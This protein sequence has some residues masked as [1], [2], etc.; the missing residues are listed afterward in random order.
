[1]SPPLYAEAM[2]ISSPRAVARPIPS[3]S[4]LPRAAA[5]ANAGWMTFVWITRIR[6]A[7]SD[8][9]ATSSA[10]AGAYALSATM[11][12][13]AAAVAVVALRRPTPSAARV[14]VRG[15]TAVHAGVWVIRGAQIATSDHTV[16]FISV[17]EG[18]AAVSLGLAAWAWAGTRSASIE[19]EAAT[20]DTA[21]V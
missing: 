21:K 5:L 10:K 9:E 16:A 2:A 8:T 18:L 11:L 13:G 19:V 20:S 12:V 14:V 7:A 6:N 1:M 17:H 15:V 3:H 4:R